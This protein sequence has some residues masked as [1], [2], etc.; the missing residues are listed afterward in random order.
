MAFVD[1]VAE[2]MAKVRTSMWRQV[3]KTKLSMVRRRCVLNE[4]QY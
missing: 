4:R 2:M 1:V 3:M